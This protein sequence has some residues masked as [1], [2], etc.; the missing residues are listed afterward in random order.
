MEEHAISRDCVM[1]ALNYERPDRPPKDLGGMLS[2]GISGFAYPKL[3]EALGLPQRLP[4]MYDTGQMLAM[5]E[6]DVLDALGTDV[7]T[8]VGRATNAFDEPEKWFPYDYNGR[9]PALVR[10][11]S[12]YITEPDGTIIKGNTRMPPT[13]V[14]FDELHGGQPLNLNAEMPKFDLQVYGRP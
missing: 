12:I 4:K 11:P 14:V 1:Q 10:D 2:S 6:L 9:L 5:P 3:V 7:V 13:S 8:I